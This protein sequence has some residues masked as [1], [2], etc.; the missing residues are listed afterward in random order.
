MRE[1][2]VATAVVVLA[3]SVVF[4]AGGVGLILLGGIATL[5][6]T[7]LI[8]FGVMGMVQ[9]VLIAFGRQQPDADADGAEQPKD[10]IQ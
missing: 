3:V 7:I 4:N 6:G 1:E 9:A 10:R 2:P 8:A 5:P